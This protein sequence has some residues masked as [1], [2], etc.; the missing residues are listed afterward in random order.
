MRQRCKLAY[1]IS[2]KGVILCYTEKGKKRDV[3]EH[4]LW[5]ICP[6]KK[7]WILEMTIFY[8]KEVGAAVT[9]KPDFGCK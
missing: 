1:L 6:S 5:N 8:D 2:S 7:R 4:I 9:D 3:W